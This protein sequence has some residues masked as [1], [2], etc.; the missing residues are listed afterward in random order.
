MCI[1]CLQLTLDPYGICALVL[2]PTRELAIQIGDQFAALG[3]PIGLKTGIIVGGK[4]RV[5][6]G[7]D[8]ARYMLKKLTVIIPLLLLNL[9]RKTILFVGDL[10]LLLQHLDD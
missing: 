5:A 8:L 2:T 1:N 4:D 3:T 9:K 7:I 6:Q 10:M